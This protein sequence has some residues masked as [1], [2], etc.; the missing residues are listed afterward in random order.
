MT[1]LRVPA[2]SPYAVAEHAMTII[3]AANRRIHKAYNRVNDN[4]FRLGGLLGI[5]LHNKIAGIMGTGRIGVCMARI[6]KGYGMTV[7]GWDAYP[8]KALEEEGLLTY[9]SKEE[10]LQRADL[11]SIHAPLIMGKGG[12]YHLI[13][14]DAI[15]L[16]KQNV[17]LVNGYKH[18]EQAEKLLDKV[19]LLEKKDKFPRQLSGGQQQRVAIR[20]S[21]HSTHQLVAVRLAANHCDGQQTTQYTGLKYSHY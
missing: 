4:N 5:D 2:Y 3:Q 20:Q 10:L 18:K 15:S 9:V 19:G 1:V 13:D 11:I 8:N 16:M 17:M 21:L 7:I 12:T 6:C 14:D